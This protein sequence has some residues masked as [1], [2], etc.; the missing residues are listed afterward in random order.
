MLTL[1]LYAY[2]KKYANG[3]LPP[4]PLNAT[5]N[6]FKPPN[7]QTKNAIILFEDLRRAAMTITIQ[8]KFEELA[9]V[10]YN[11]LSVFTQFSKRI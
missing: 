11:S 9:S 5:L 8:A 2:L 3:S 4:P 1:L 7:H 6:Q 10:I